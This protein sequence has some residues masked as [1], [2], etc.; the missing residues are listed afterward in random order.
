MV[1][2]DE[3][4]MMADGHVIADGDRRAR[5]QEQRRRHQIVVAN[6]DVARERAGTRKRH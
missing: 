6:P 5:V 3:G 4:D 2:R 1:I